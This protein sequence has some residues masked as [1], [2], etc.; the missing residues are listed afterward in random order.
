MQAMLIVVIVLLAYISYAA[1]YLLG[2]KHGCNYMAEWIDE[3]DEENDD[4]LE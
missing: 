2:Y 4:K 1:A 3:K